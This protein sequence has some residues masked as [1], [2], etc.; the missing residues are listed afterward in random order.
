M[1]KTCLRASVA[2][3]LSIGLAGFV[4]AGQGQQISTP[5][6]GARQTAEDLGHDSL[7]ILKMDIEGAEYA[8]LHNVLENSIPV[9][10]L[11]V[12]FHHRWR[13]I[14]VS[15]TREAISALRARGYRIFHISDSG[16]EYSFLGP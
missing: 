7:D 15:R 3:P 6:S 12:E 14:G 11:C 9:T 5:I 13:E 10:Q 16:E 8:V 1:A 4:Y 2:V